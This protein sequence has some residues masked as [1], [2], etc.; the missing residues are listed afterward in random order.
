MSGHLIPGAAAKYS[1]TER[2]TCGV[3]EH[4][5]VL[6]PVQLRPLSDCPSSI[7]TVFARRQSERRTERLMLLFKGIE[8]GENGS[9]RCARERTVF[10]LNCREQV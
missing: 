1:E 10:S 6:N 9:D 4:T 8:T 7:T 5:T 3:H 2:S